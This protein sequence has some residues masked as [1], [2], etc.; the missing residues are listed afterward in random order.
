[1][2]C[3]FSMAALNFSGK[4]S[5][6]NSL[7]SAKGG[8]SL[9]ADLDFSSNRA[10][11][12]A[13]TSALDLAILAANLNFSGTGGSANTFEW[14]DRGMSM[15]AALDVSVCG[16]GPD[17]PAPAAVWAITM[18]N[19]NFSGRAGGA[20]TTRRPDGRAS[21][22]AAKPSWADNGG[23]IDTLAAATALA[24]SEAN[25]NLSSRAGRAHTFR[26]AD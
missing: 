13:N 9:T 3:T 14:A 12:K 15:E 4:G 8:A 18:A 23:G 21:A 17:N 5:S 26:L 6:L 25:F 20:N 16:R 1:M 24:I 2:A 19:L 10:G 11:P 7:A 22:V